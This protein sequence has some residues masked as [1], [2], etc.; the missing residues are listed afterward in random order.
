[1]LRNVVIGLEI[2]VQLLTRSKMFCGCSTQF[3]A[4]PNS[5]TCP[6][7]LGLPGSLPVTNRRAIELGLRTALALH[8][9]L[10]ERSQFHRKNYYYPDIPKN[11]QIS[12]YQYG[13]HP[14]LAVDGWMEIDIEGELRRMGI[15][16]VHL[17]EDTG[18]LVHPEGA[19]FSLVDYNRSGVPLME[20][21]TQPELRSPAEAR[22]FLNALRQILQYAEVSIGRMEEGAMRCDANVSLRGP[23][24]ALGTRTEIKN[25]NSVRAVE[26]ALAFEA[27]RQAEVLAAGGVVVQETRH[28]DER[29]GV[30]FGSR[31]KEEAHDY[32]YFPE[33]D[34]APIRVDAAWVRDVA[35]SLPEMPEA[36]AR[37]F[38]AAYGLG[39]YEA[40]LLVATKSPADFY[41]AAVAAHANP[42]A[43][44][45]WQLGDV[46]AYLNEHALEIEDLRS[47]PEHLAALV[48]LID[49]GTISGR[50]AK[51]VLAEMLAGG[52][53]PETIVGRRGWV[54][55]S[56]E[57]ALR[58]AISAV[59]ASH[60]GPVADVR[61]GKEK[62]IGFLVGQVM[63]RTRGKA[64][65]GVV[66]R[67]LKQALG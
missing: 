32:R 26:R 58:E 4:P 50:I 16:R 37:R 30:T 35:G 7:C 52:E 54:Q 28:W 9:D 8:C 21:V 39:E 29:L 10:G 42:K 20:V 38:A 60:P 6:V 31:G 65:P 17:E 15:R 34:L 47:R 13:V 51:E 49:D 63:K 59:I 36:R 55:I 23:D 18:K 5:Q 48:R 66:N 1:M 22:V 2:H 25:L 40:G 53:E 44:A 24:G 14:P 12:Q 43:I 64:N 33:P 46:A 57:D 11:Y 67:L 56:D 62:A 45:N 3:G 61:S 19:D 27:Q 41:E